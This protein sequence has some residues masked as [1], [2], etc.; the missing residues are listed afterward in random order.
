MWSYVGYDRFQYFRRGRRFIPRC[1]KMP[2]CFN[3]LHRVGEQ[4]GIFF[5]RL[6]ERFD[7][8]AKVLVD[9]CG[10]QASQG[11]RACIWIGELGAFHSLFACNECVDRAL[12]IMQGGCLEIDPQSFVRL[13]RHIRGG[14][15]PEILFGDR[16]D[17]A[18]GL[19]M[20]F[21]LQECPLGNDRPGGASAAAFSD[22][23]GE[24]RNTACPSRKRVNMLIRSEA[25]GGIYR[26]SV[27][28]AQK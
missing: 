2:D 27:T 28:K 9:C 8:L 26:Q 17:I 23:A 4:R 7:M 19:A 14:S 3:A 15:R 6:G 13:S 24:G 11:F 5:H 25:L 10:L 22:I 21:S 12:A 1:T 16:R 20:P 18:K